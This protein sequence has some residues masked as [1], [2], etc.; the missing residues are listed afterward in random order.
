MSA[1]RNNGVR[2]RFFTEPGEF[3]ASVGDHLAADPVV[4][5]VVTT[6]AHRRLSQLAAGMPTPDRDWWL[7]VYDDSG[8]VVG[9]GMRAAPSAPYPL[10][11]LPMPDE[12][13]VAL[14]RTLHER[15]EE[16]LA[17]NGALPGVELCA[18]E[19]V[20]L[21]GGR[22]EV[23]RHTRLHELG[24]LV[25]PRPVPGLLVAATGDDL[26]L[27]ARWFDAFVGDADEQA[28]RTRGDGAHEIH[29]RA[30]LLRRIESGRL[31]FWVDDTGAPVH[32]TGA[33][34]PSFGVARIGPVYTPPGQRGRGWAGNA[35]AEV[36]RRIQ[37]EGAR[38]CLFTDQANPTSNKIYAALGYRPVVDMANLVISR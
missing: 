17:V 29:D 8:A 14:A 22:V 3:L 16:V 4:S 9:A 24:E 1:I 15:G 21:G 20:R 23:G 38:A 19:L 12:A 13:A 6:A 37:A 18:A 2:L 5:T 33:N 25:G 30:E 11:L 36:S 34:P 28:G 35:V 7:A 27:V 31:W 10:F 26:D 32:L